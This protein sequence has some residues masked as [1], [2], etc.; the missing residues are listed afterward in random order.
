MKTNSSKFTKAVAIIILTAV[1]VLAFFSIS[2]AQV[3]GNSGLSPTYKVWYSKN[4]FVSDTL[5]AERII[6]NKRNG[7]T[8]T[9][10]IEGL[11][12][13]GNALLVSP[14]GGIYKGAGGGRKL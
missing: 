5:Y 1:A 12:G 7:T 6:A 9:I 13:S 4:G 14:T 8:D 3:N 2:G 11:S 10:Y